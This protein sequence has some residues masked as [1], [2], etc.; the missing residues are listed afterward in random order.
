MVLRV[1]FPRTLKPIRPDN[2]LIIARSGATPFPKAEPGEL[3]AILPPV[4]VEPSPAVVEA[5]EAAATEVLE[6][7]VDATVEEVAPEVAPEAVAEVPTLYEA[8]EINAEVVI[9][10][11]APAAEVAAEE[12]PEAKVEEAVEEVPA[13]E[14]PEVEASHWDAS[15]K[16][17]D[18][19]AAAEALGLDLPA[20]ATKAEIIAALKAAEV[21]A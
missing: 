13:I 12:V 1:V 17:A 6:P 15:M 11:D 14:S 18:L 10:V 2:V 5:V 8:G 20:T 4:A 9:P 16:K 7:V 19:Q 21:V 3:V